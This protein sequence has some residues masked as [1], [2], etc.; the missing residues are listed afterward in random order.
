MPELLKWRLLWFSI[1]GVSFTA[2]VVWLFYWPGGGL[3]D[4]VGYHL[5]RDFINV[6]TGP[7]VV[8]RFGSMMLLDLKGY[9]SAQSGIV[10]FNILFHNWSYP[11]DFLFVAYP[12]SWLPYAPA[13]AVWTGLGLAIYVAVVASRIPAEQR[14][15]AILF[16]LI[17]PA[18]VVNIIGGQN[19]FYTAALIL[20]AIALLDRRPWLAGVLLGLLTMKPHLGV[21]IGVVLLVT[22][23]WRTIISTGV[24]AA[25]LV[26]AS[27]W[28]WGA[29]PWM[30]YL[31]ET[32]AHTFEVLT[33]FEG[34]QKLMTLS[35]LSSLRAF[36]LPVWLAE[37]VQAAA[38][39][40]AI[41]TSALLFRRTQDVA[42]RALLVT[43][44]TFLA[45]P[46]VFNYD[47]PIL[48]GAIL[49]VMTSKPVGNRE[50]L[51]LGAA[52][53]VAG[54]VWTLHLAHLGLAPFAYGGAFVVA[55][56]LI[57]REQASG[58]VPQAIP[59][60]A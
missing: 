22:L 30:T 51:V 4:T 52:W 43:S 35:V 37:A 15:L 41:A 53:I 12:F 44:G 25:V 42:L 11:I 27:V 56:R 29:G 31:T 5:G 33:A 19:G 16:L 21:V 49:W 23:A 57:L 18:T 45:S 14:A 24:T 58:N 7:Q 38:S 13:L 36:G 6:W 54:A 34:F 3:L 55:V 48:T 10:G 8:D 2:P 1:I 17:A 9:H 28:M 46:Y 60:P 32:S 26:G 40:C 59:Q 50:S 20:G 47:L 39:L